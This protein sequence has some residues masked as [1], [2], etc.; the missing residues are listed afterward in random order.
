MKI[1]YLTTSALVFIACY[2]LLI[3]YQGYKANPWTRDAQVRAHIVEI[4]PQVTGQV[5]RVLIDDNQRVQ[6]GDLLFEIDSSVYET[7]YRKLQAAVRQAQ[8]QLDKASN[9]S[10]RAQSLE[11]RTPSSVS[12]LNLNNLSNAVKAASA[13][14]QAQQAGAKEAQLN[15]QFTKI[16]APVDGFITNLRLRKGSQVVANTPVVALIDEHSFWVE[17]FFKETELRAVTIHDRAQV[18]LLMHND[19]VLEAEVSSIGYGIAKQDGATGNDLLPNVNP[20]FQWIRLAQRIPLKIS[21]RDLPESLQLRVG[22]SAS[23]K[24]FGPSVKP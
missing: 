6:K 23:V 4:T 20:N 11:K 13:N 2:L 22:M 21:L 7:K 10:Q 1:R 8:V 5:I 19:L 14:L 12:Q 18:T 17:G 24:I 9:E 3:Q 15:L 16:Y